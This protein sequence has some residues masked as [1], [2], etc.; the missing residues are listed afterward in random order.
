MKKLS[1]SELEIM[2]ILWSRDG[3]M[4]SNEI[5]D[6]IKGQRDWKLAS[7]MTALA[8]MVEKGYVYCDRSTRTNYYTAVVGEEQYKVEESQQL[9]D[10]LF[11]K[12]ATKMIASLYHGKKFSSQELSELK[13]YI[14][15]LEEKEKCRKD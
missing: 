11:N 12:S 6:G 5:L 8:R 2:K 3:A 7:L 4:T 10:R 9:L 13:A 1:E 14:N 15:S